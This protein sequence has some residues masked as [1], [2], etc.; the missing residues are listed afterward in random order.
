MKKKDNAIRAFI[1]V[2][3]L[4][5]FFYGFSIAGKKYPHYFIEK[6][7]SKKNETREIKIILKTGASMIKSY[8]RPHTA[9]DYP[10]R[11][12]VVTL[13]G[14]W[15][16]MGKQYGL[17][18]A[19]YIRAV[20]DGFYKKWDEKPFGIVYLKSCLKKYDEQTRA[21]SPEMA[22]FMEGISY[23]AADSLDRSRYSGHLTNYEKILFINCA[24]EMIYCDE[25]HEKLTGK[26]IQKKNKNQENQ[27]GD[28]FCTCWAALPKSTSLGELITG[29]NRDFKYYPALYQ[30]A[31]K[32]Y[33]EDS[34]AKSFAFTAPAGLVGS[35]NCINA[36]GLY[37]GQTRVADEF[38]PDEGI[39]EMSFGVP[40][41][42]I[43]AHM[44]SYCNNV[45]KAKDI[46][47]YGTEQYREK[48]KRKTLLHSNCMNYLLAKNNKALVVER[49]ANHYAIRYPGDMN[50]DE[51]SF[52]ATTN[53]FTCSYS[54]NKDGIRTDIPMTLYGRNAKNKGAGYSVARLDSAI[55][56]L[57]VY[58]KRMNVN[59]GQNEI[60]SLITYFDSMG[61]EHY[62]VKR[63]EKKI[64]AREIGYSIDNQR[65]K[66]GVPFAGTIAAHVNLPQ[67]GI[68][69]YVQGSPHDWLGLWD[70]IQIGKEEESTD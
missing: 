22:S 23:G 45:D 30:V 5:G 13:S 47:I 29:L 51:K 36:D 59:L 57:H 34:E 37:I 69:Y 24:M 38:R 19:G 56:Q 11:M 53:H 35:N 64:L 44:T 1:V 66:N 67:E 58:Y 27:P 26:K 46:L 33:P 12:P 17:E 50:E 48:T 16:D 55:H 60:C 14:S 21:F 42:I 32:A 63:D 8:Y 61:L 20:Y 65:E 10:N 3:L 39:E 7:Y 6:K 2:L 43:C 54:Y 31:I 70:V 41:S 52:I 25:W 18:C 15:F 49:S 68:M 9:P 28:V 62:H 4:L 40:A